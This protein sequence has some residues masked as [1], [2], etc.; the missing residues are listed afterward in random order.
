MNL[1]ETKEIIH[2]GLAWA[3]WTDEQQA[4]MREALKCVHLVEQIRDEAEEL[5][6]EKIDLLDFGERVANII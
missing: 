2:A 6:E 1:K 3:N 5:Y 4:A